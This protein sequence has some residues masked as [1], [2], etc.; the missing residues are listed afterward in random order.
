MNRIN[1]IILVVEDEEYMAMLIEE[2]LSRR[3]YTH[4]SVNN[5]NDA[6]KAHNDN[7]IAVTLVDIK[8]PG[9]NGLE[10]LEKVLS[11]DSRA[12]VIMITAYGTIEVAVDAM[13]KGAFDFITKP[14]E[15]DELE[16][17]VD[18]AMSTWEL[19]SENRR[20]REQLEALT[21]P[22]QL[23]GNSMSMER[24]KQLV[25]KVAKTDY[26][27]LIT[28]ES[29][30]GKSLLAKTIYEQ[31]RRRSKPF[32]NVN[33]AAIPANLIE[34]ELFGHEKGAFTGAYQR[35]CGKFERANQGTIFLDEISTLDLRAQAKLLQVLQEQQFERVGGSETLDIDVRVIAASNQNLKHLVEQGEFREDLFFRLNVIPIEMPSLRE[36][37]EDI[38]PI[39]HYLL[40]RLQAGKEL[41]IT[42][43]TAALLKN[44]RWPGNIR[45][46]ENV[47][48]QTIVL[49]GNDEVILP[50]Y[51]PQELHGRQTMTQN[52]DLTI[53]GE[54][55]KEIME[56]LERDII[57]KTIKK[58]G[59]NTRQ[60]AKQL[61][62]PIRT[63]YFRMNKLNIGGAEKK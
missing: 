45:E 14:F 13:R 25:S 5:G 34:S 36:R 62:L 58:C 27:I 10:V 30:T 33:C 29:G 39:A 18:K 54:N 3:G 53:K 19:V 47:L 51:L 59:W 50:D 1:P 16:Q 48:K 56:N 41:L 11:I 46:M 23:V 6:L 55:L 17:V 35:K 32:I 52:E 38:I 31:S 21:G 20:L 12:I 2:V 61:G 43:E 22:T 37:K 4:I 57:I 8:I 15:I 7:P 24:I 49:I 44:Y 9:P 60:A 26:S 42:P 63:L 40:H 28:G